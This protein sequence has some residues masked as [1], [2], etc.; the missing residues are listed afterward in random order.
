MPLPARTSRE[1]FR[2]LQ[3]YANGILNKVLTRYRLEFFVRTA[4]QDQATLAFFD[5]RR[6]AVTVS[7]PPSLWYL[8][9]GLELKAVPEEQGYGLQMLK[10]AYAEEAE[11]AIK[12]VI[13]FRPAT[14][15]N[16]LSAL[17]GML[18]EASRW[19]REQTYLLTRERW[20]SHKTF[21]V[22]L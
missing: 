16:L 19:S 11:Q 8:H 2:A 13:T 14:V 9:L 6:V 12:D 17:R 10:Y 3:S 4:A 15:N 22:A 18:K 1:A 5:R 21:G 7:L 20:I